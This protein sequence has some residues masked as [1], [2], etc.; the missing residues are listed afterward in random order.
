MFSS[1]PY[2]GQIRGGNTSWAYGYASY[3]FADTLN[4]FNLKTYAPDLQNGGLHGFRSDH[5]GGGNFLLTDGSVRFVSESI[6]LTTYQALATRAGGEVV[7]GN[8]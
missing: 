7:P 5:S 8:W 2:A 3:S 1:G 4:R 6:P